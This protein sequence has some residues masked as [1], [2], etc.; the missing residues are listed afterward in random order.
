VAP[1]V[2]PRKEGDLGDYFV[3]IADE[4]AFEVH[5]LDNA[6]LQP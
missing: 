3:S 6:A 4:T 5:F 2:Q 1:L